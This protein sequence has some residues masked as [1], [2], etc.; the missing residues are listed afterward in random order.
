MSATDK[1]I[2]ALDFPSL[3][4]AEKCLA[5]LPQLKWVKVGMELFYAEGPQVVRT[6]KERGYNIF[7][8]LKLHDIPNT[9]YGGTKSLLNL[10]ANMLNYHV[11]GGRAML[12]AAVQAATEFSGPKPILIGVTQLTSTNQGVLEEEIL[13]RQPLSEVVL[14]YASLT[15]EAGLDGVVCSAQETPEIKE[16]VGSDFLT[17]TP[18]IRLSAETA[19]DQKRVVTPKAALDNGSDFLV[20]GRP[21]T[22]AQEPE[23]VWAEIQ[24][25]LS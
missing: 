23:A 8:D 7:L 3:A 19:Q 21:L 12:E 16:Q 6:L 15:K 10:G 9:V 11:A 1:L 4:D 5:R 22:R 17:V 25:Q 2:L 24:R 18:G 14:S 13:I 20:I